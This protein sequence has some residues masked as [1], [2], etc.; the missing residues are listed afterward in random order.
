MRQVA[1]Q[2]RTTLREP[3]ARAH[4]MYSVAIMLLSLMFNP[5]GRQVYPISDADMQLQ[6]GNHEVVMLRTSASETFFTQEHLAVKL[7]Y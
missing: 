3:C 1:G 7:C 5:G 4:G 6:T 2:L